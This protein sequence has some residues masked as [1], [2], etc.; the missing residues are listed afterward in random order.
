MIF[1]E[2][3]G[4][5]SEN[6]FIEVKANVQSRL[7]LWRWRAVYSIVAFLLSCACVYPFVDGQKLSAG[8]ELLKQG[9]LLVAFA[10]LLVALYCSL[11]VWGAWRSLRDLERG[12]L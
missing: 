8:G 7:R 4:P 9:A 3:E 10:L 2:A 12:R 6:E 11:L 5:L 1:E